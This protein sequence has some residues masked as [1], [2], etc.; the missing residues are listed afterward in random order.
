MFVEAV[1]AVEAVVEVVVPP[2]LQSGDTL[3]QQEWYLACIDNDLFDKW[4][5]PNKLFVGCKL[6]KALQ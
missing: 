1:K 3:H 2:L 6:A 4:N 5:F